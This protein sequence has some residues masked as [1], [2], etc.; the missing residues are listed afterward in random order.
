[1][2]HQ[3]ITDAQRATI[4][5]AVRTLTNEMI[6]AAE[7]ADIDSIIVNSND[8]YH[9]GFISNGVFYPSVD[10]LG[11]AFRSSHLREQK[12]EM[13]ETR[14]S[15]LAHNVAVLTAHGNLSATDTTGNTFE[16]LF[17]WTFIYTKVNDDWK[18]T[19]SHQS[20]TNET[21]TISG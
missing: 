7:Q 16:S 2:S 14:I 9:T 12:I 5:D 8:S 17:A 15:V 10:S 19:H 21:Y 4:E 20:F 3:S 1:M 11:A 13:S 6:S 18:I